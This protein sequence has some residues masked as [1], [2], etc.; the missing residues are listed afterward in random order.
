MQMRQILS[1]QKRGRYLVISVTKF[2]ISDCLRNVKAQQSR[3]S[4]HVEGK[5]EWGRDVKTFDSEK[6]RKR[7]DKEG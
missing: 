7:N 4:F 5:G 6:N 2:Q 3:R 1:G